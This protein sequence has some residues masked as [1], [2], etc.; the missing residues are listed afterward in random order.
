MSPEMEETWL[1]EREASVFGRSVGTDLAMALGRNRARD[2][3]IA[4]VDRVVRGLMCP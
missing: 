1:A 4:D 3:R 2:K